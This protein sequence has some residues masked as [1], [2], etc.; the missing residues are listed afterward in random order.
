MASLQSCLRLF[1]LWLRHGLSAPAVAA[2]APAHSAALAL[3]NAIG[4]P[5]SSEDEPLP[6]P[7]PS[8]AAI[9]RVVDEEFKPVME[10]PKE[11]VILAQVRGQAR[12]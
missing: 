6:V 3:I 11:M 12:R 9:G 10:G 2:P 4:S 5:T 1:V 8:S 7:G